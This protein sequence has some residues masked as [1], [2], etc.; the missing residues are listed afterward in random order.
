MSV[1]DLVAGLRRATNDWWLCHVEGGAFCLVRSTA[2]PWNEVRRAFH[3]GAM[4]RGAACVPRWS[5]G[6]R[7][8]VRSTAE[9]WNEVLEPWNDV[10]NLRCQKLS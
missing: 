4:E 1:V 10:E 2:E 3:G 7:C 5:H 6:T 9:V 8:G